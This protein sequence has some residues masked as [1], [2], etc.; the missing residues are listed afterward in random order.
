M[1][2]LLDFKARSLQPPLMS[3]ELQVFQP[4]PHQKP[5]L[6]LH[7]DHSPSPV[8]RSQLPQASLPLISLEFYHPG[9]YPEIPS[10]SLVQFF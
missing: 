3:Q 6:A 7:P 9:V 5:P 2:S 10:Q 4:R 1:C 8:M